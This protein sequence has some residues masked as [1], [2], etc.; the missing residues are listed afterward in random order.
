MY[1]EIHLGDIV[2]L[3]KKHP[4]GST[5]WEVVRV[6]ADIGL[7]CLKCQHRIML[8]RGTFNKRLKTILKNNQTSDN[9]DL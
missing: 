4:C 2:R 1:V 3:R 5:D 8:P 9:S 6:G 7:V